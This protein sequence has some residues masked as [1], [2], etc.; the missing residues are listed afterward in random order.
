MR[1][2]IFLF[3][4]SQTIAQGNFNE[5]SV[6]EFKLTK[7]I[8]MLQGAGGNVGLVL[9]KD[10][11]ALVIDSQYEQM[12]DKLRA[13]IKAL[14][15]K[16]IHSIINTHWHSD[17]TGGNSLFQKTGS[18]IIAH[19][20]ARQRMSMEQVREDRIIPP[21]D[22]AALPVITFSEGM[23]LYQY[24][25]PVMLFHVHDAHTDGDVIVWLPQSNVIH[26]GDCFFHKRFPFIDIESG[27]T[28]SGLINA[29]ELVLL[30]IDEDT[31]IIPSHGPVA[32]YQDL[33]GYLKFLTIIRDKINRALS[34]GIALSDVHTGALIKGYELWAW[35]LVS[36]E[37]LKTIFYNSLARELED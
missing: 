32:N 2:F 36:A 16:Q 31:Q 15:G 33:T 1:V 21:V 3:L 27:G 18:I 34:A 4:S 12:N 10:G 6:N 29:I 23:Q 9:S 24:D 7:N 22:D 25:E 30:L 20:N 17:H 37:R 26:L 11:R 19:E 14:G 28:V 5:V 13:K 35:P 8:F